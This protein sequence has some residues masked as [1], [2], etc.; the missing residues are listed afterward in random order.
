[1]VIEPDMT[2]IA[3]TDFHRAE[4]CIKRGALMAQKI[5]PEIKHRLSLTE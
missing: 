3:F 5:I 2:G 1:V 4:E